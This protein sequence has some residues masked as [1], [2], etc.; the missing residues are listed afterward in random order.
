[1]QHHDYFR[2]YGHAGQSADLRAEVEW[3]PEIYPDSQIFPSLV[4]GTA[5]VRP[6]NEV[7]AISVIS[8]AEL[9]HGV[10]RA[11]SETRRIKRTM[12]VEKII[13]TFSIFPFDLETSRIYAKLWSDLLKDGIKIGP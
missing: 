7:F 13:D 8:V 3:D 12:F 5:T 4:I 6:E 11:D 2:K 9:L 10:H 1:M